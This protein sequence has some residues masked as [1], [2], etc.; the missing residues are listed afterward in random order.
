MVQILTSILIDLLA[1]FIFKNNNDNKDENRTFIEHWVFQTHY[2]PLKIASHLIHKLTYPKGA[3]IILSL[4]FEEQ[5]WK[6]CAIFLRS[7]S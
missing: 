7:Q 1:M 4:H 3:I 5:G 2:N 6:D